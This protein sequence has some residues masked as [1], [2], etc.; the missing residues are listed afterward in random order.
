MSAPRII[1][2]PEQPLPANPPQS[3]NPH[4][5]PPIILSESFLAHLRSIAEPGRSIHPTHHLSQILHSLP[6]RIHSTL[7]SSTSQTAP[8]A[9]DA[10][11]PDSLRKLINYITSP[12]SNAATTPPALSDQDLSFPLSNYFINSSHNTYLTG[13]Q[14]YSE[15]STDAYRNVRAI[16]FCYSTLSSMYITM[17]SSRLYTTIRAINQLISSRTQGPSTWMPLHRNRRLG[18]RSQIVLFFRIRGFNRSKR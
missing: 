18:W 2:I 6:S 8:S 10:Q 14:L 9:S 4:P 13:N 16:C 3:Q 15:S 12:L 5:T 7:S 11:S 1:P 17:T